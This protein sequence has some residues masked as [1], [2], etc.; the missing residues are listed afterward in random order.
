MAM[1][2]ILS[3][4]YV[5]SPMI[6]LEPKTTRY[7]RNSTKM[8]KGNYWAV[9]LLY[10][11]TTTLLTILNRTA[12]HILMGKTMLLLLTAIAYY[13][14]YFFV[15]PFAE[16]VRV[17]VYRQLSKEKRDIEKQNM[18]EGNPAM[19]CGNCGAQVDQNA[20]ICLQ[21]GAHFNLS[22]RR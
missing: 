1:G 5:M 13:L 19:Y 14:I 22:P 3:F 15:F 8:I 12:T 21:C 10:F 6:A 11:I 4:Y 9:L 7:L 20:Y 18:M 16:T 2:F 17:I